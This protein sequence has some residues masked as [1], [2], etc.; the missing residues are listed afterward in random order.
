MKLKD[1]S[2]FSVYTI[3]VLIIGY[4]FCLYHKPIFRNIEAMFTVIVSLSTFVMT[5]INF[6]V[7]TKERKFNQKIEKSRIK[8][9]RNSVNVFRAN[10]IWDKNVS[11]DNDD[12]KILKLNIKYI[13]KNAKSY[14]LIHY[15]DRVTLF[16]EKIE[17]ASAEKRQDMINDLVE[18]VQQNITVI[19][20]GDIF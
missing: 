5:V 10:K 16:L 6:Q 12:I 14:T 8:E 2:I 11:L 3:V 9:L 15:F 13:L 18:Y 7:A 20:N 1:N 19:K 4:L 17:S